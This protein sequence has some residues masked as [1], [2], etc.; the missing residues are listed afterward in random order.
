MAKLL[1]ER[2]FEALFKQWFKPLTAYAYKYLQDIDLAKEIVHQA[3]LK[4]WE[5]RETIDTGQNVKS[6]LYKTVTNLSINYIRDNKKFVSTEEIYEWNLDPE[7]FENLAERN[8]LAAAL[9]NAIDQL[10]PKMREIFILS[11]YDGL[12]HKEIAEKLGIS[13]KTV[14][15]QIGKALKKLRKTLKPYAEL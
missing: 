11:R 2:K 13:T 1:D 12:S 9:L 6:Y 14:E 15:N 7:D 5:T 8:E 10:P 4:L 3:F